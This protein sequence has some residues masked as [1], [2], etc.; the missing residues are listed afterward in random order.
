MEAPMLDLQ[1]Q[2][3]LVGADTRAA[4]SDVIASG[5]CI[6]GPKVE[7]LE[8]ALA[9]FV[10]AAQTLAI[11]VYLELTTQMQDHVIETL[12]AFYA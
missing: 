2:L 12:T 4:V 3:E 11:P 10:A 5:H 6:L 7:A 8:A 9:D 1:A